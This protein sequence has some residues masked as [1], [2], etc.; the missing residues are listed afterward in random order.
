MANRAFFGGEESA[1]LSPG[2][3]RI[4]T[5]HQNTDNTTS[6]SIILLIKIQF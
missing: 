3:A 5:L 4:R 1:S 2:P 6:S